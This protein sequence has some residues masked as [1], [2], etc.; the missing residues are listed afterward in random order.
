MKTSSGATRDSG[1]IKLNSIEDA[2]GYLEDK[3]LNKLKQN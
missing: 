1:D 3:K 2:L